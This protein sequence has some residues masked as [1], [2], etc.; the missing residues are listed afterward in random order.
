MTQCTK[1]K[2]IKKHNLSK[3]PDRLWKKYFFTLNQKRAQKNQKV[4]WKQFK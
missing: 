2:Q 3:Y 4:H 1:N